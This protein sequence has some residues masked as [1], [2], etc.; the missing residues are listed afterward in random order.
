MGP[1][2]QWGLF[3]MM[4]RQY[5]LSRAT[6]GITSGTTV[7]SITSIFGIGNTIGIH[8]DCWKGHVT[9]VPDVVPDVI[10]DV[11]PDVALLKT[12]CL[13]IIPSSPCCLCGP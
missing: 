8:E 5:V 7:T 3:R 10:P 11:V 4:S 6:S 9:V 2:A 1:Q 13:H 12:Y